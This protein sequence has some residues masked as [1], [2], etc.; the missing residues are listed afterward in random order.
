MFLWIIGSVIAAYSFAVVLS[1]IF[2]CHPVWSLWD[3]QGDYT[4]IRFNVEFCV[5]ASLNVVTDIVTLALPMPLLW[6]LQIDRQQK[7]QLMGIF[8]LGGL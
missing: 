2:Q 6:R 7:L 5:M 1:I 8:L 3:P 4:C